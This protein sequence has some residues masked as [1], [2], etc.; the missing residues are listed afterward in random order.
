MKRARWLAPLLCLCLCGFS[1]EAWAEM[2][3]VR[4][5]DNLGNTLAEEVYVSTEESFAS[6]V[7]PAREGK[8]FMYWEAEP[9]QPHLTARDAWGRALDAAKVI[10]KDAIVT[11]TAVYGDAN[12]DENKNGMSDAE[13]TYW[14]GRS[15]GA[16]EDTDGDGYTF[17]E[18]LQYGMNPLFPNT[19]ALG[20][21]AWGDGEPLLYNPNGYATYRV[22]SEPEGKLFATY[23]GVAKPGETI[24]TSSYAPTSSTFAYWT[25][26]GARQK[27]A[28]GVSLNEVKWFVENS[29]PLEF[30]AHC[31]EDEQA[32]QA[33]YWYGGEA[34]PDSDSDGDGYT[35]AEELQYGMNP[36]F[37]NALVLGG[38]AYGDGPLSQYNPNGYP[39][40]TLRSEPE[41]VF[42]TE[43]FILRPGDSRET[44][45][46]TPTERFRGWS[47]NAERQADAWGRAFDKL[48]LVGGTG[49]GKID[50]VAT[51]DDN[52]RRRLSQ[53]WYG[54]DDQATD[55]D[56][57]GDG[58]TFAEELQY[59]MN[60]LF[61]NTLALGGV[62]CGD[63]PV[64]E[65]NLQI[66]DQASK[67]LFNGTLK[68]FFATGGG[69]GGLTGGKD[70]GGAVAPAV[71]GLDGNGKFDFL[72]FAAGTLTVYRNIGTEGSP[73]F[74]EEPGDETL[75]ETLA[76]LDRPVLCGGN[77]DGKPTVWFC[78]DGGDVFAYDFASAPTPTGLTGFPVWESKA[79]FGV[80]A[81]NTLTLADDTKLTCDVVPEAVT[82][83]A[84]AEATG[85]EKPDL[86]VADA[87]GRVSLYERVGDGFVLRRRVWGGSYE[88]FAEGLTLAPVDWDSD[89]DLDALCGTADG[90]L[91][92]LSDPKAGKPSNLRATAGYDNVLLEWDPNGQSRV[93]GYNVHRA[94]ASATD[95]ALLA[96]TPL[97]SY[98]DVP[99]STAEWAYRVTAL[100]RRWVAGN[101][102]PKVFESAPSEVVKVTLGRVTLALPEAVKAYVGQVLVVPLT[103]A[104]T[105]NLPATVSLTFTCPE[106]LE[107][108]GFTPSA[109]A[110]GLT[111]TSRAE[112]GTWTLTSTSG[113][114]GSG[115]GELLRLRFRAKTAAT[116]AEVR[117]TQAA[118]ALTERSNVPVTPELP[119]ITKVT[120]KEPPT[121]A[122][123]TLRS[124]E[125]TAGE[126]VD[127]VEAPLTLETTAELKWEALSL[128]PTY[129]A[130]LLELVS[131]PEI[132]G[133]GTHTYTFRVLKRTNETQVAEVRFTGS[134]QGSN[135]LAAEVKPATGRVIIPAKKPSGSAFIYLKTVTARGPGV[136]PDDD[137]DEDEF[138][139]KVGSQATVYVKATA[140]GAESFNWGALKLTASWKP[141]A[142]LEQVGECQLLKEYSSDTVAYFS[143]T[144]LVKTPPREDDDDDWEDDINIVFTGTAPNAKVRPAECEFEIEGRLDPSFVPPW[145]NGDVD[146][147]G[148]LTGNDCQ[149]AFRLSQEYHKT[150]KP[151][152]DKPHSANG[153]DRRAHNSLLMAP[154]IDDPMR[155]NDIPT[156]YA[157][158]PLSRGVPKK[159]IN[160]GNG[161]K[162]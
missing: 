117:L 9:A 131:A 108:L 66:F 129:D 150:G 100:S 138:D 48:T 87:K 10:P 80:F 17:A 98:R 136:K 55:S 38:V 133:T 69:E 52:E 64:R 40:I 86:L 79:G 118:F 93:C 18:E 85:D 78:D 15:V 159:E 107:P 84:L 143:F 67:V 90:H 102:E 46:Y 76:K 112:G 126:K 70:F 120:L 144:F 59:G 162:K 161:G 88:G 63:G 6:V 110:K 139:V 141:R 29:T 39:E 71:V 14:Y 50:V 89:G 7:A 140:K 135:G 132:A 28:W 43:T 49:I 3:T 58:Y 53:Y 111:L 57:D 146:G 116:E 124:A 26:N 75:R 137:D 27:D 125:V 103:V 160:M 94:N 65:V 16:N 1:A 158:Y 30:V 20:G 151:N 77:P 11:L 155:H 115:A 127:T 37:P 92:L 8:R 149:I 106:S 121:P 41:G 61:P 54:K 109:L 34:S 45:A 35:F 60:P 21:V 5:K 154:G 2:A 152:K 123:V 73:D 4:Q 148:R 96:E 42:P 56:T 72:A 105:H 47:K 74:A 31:V 19:L 83:A 24:A 114:L 33:Y 145:T 25:V 101:S 62:A 119:L 99:P 104:N 147:D 128:T 32:R 91:A 44:N 68:D 23:T 157:R 122:V 12:L 130:A 142:S 95:F 36:V 22:R 51:F 82:S 156:T 97:P 13:E 153:N 134:V 81:G 113:T